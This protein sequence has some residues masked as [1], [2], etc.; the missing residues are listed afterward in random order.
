MMNQRIDIGGVEI[1]NLTLT[2]CLHRLGELVANR[3]PVYV[4]TPNVDHV[5]KLQKDVDFRKVYEQS[6]MNLAD[7]VP[8][9]WA[10]K[11]L[12]TPLK[13]KISGSDLLPVIC[14]QAAQRGFKL[15]LMGGRPAAADRAAVKL[16]EQFPGLQIVGTHCP[17]LGFEKDETQNQQ[18]IQLIKDAKPDILFV[19]LGAPKQEKWIY[20]WHAQYAVAVSIGVGVSFEFVAGMVKR[21]PAWM[22]KIGL[23]WFWRIMM[24]P[25]RLW[26][27]YLIE[28]MQ[29]FPL[30]LKQKLRKNP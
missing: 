6:A 4:I 14:Q 3:K 22:Q 2:E 19:G 18:I 21:A 16:R 23:E 17:P 7:G 8:L 5:V 25:G 26:R 20:R 13:E 27:R 9:L 11:F 12:G 10:A 30:I 15:F 28:D 29:F 1:D 24:E